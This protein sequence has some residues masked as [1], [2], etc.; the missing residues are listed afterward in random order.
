MFAD[1]TLLTA[2]CRLARTL[3]APRCTPLP[4]SLECFPLERLLPPRFLRGEKVAEGRMRG[5]QIRRAINHALPELPE[6]VAHAR[7]SC[8]LERPLIRPS[9]TFSPTKSVGEKALDWKRD[10]FNKTV[11]NA[12]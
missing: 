11:R 5:E 4:F 12:G 7:M 8:S 9:T 6:N 3:G 1:L 10:Q 2:S